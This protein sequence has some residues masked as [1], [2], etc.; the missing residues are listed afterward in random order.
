VVATPIGNLADLSPRAREVL[1]EV[2][3]VLAEDTRRVRKLFAIRTGVW[4]LHEHN[5]AREVPRLLAELAAGSDLALV[6]DAGTPLLA[7]PGYRL[8]KACREHGVPVL[9]VPGPSAAT[10][11]VAVSG[12]PPVPFTFGGFLPARAGPSRLEAYG[13]PAH[14]LVLLLSPHRLA[15]ELGACASHLGQAREAAL[16]AELTKVHER[17]VRGTLAEL[18][19]WAAGTQPRGEYTLVVAPPPAAA[20]PSPSPDA[21]RAAVDEA[22]ARGLDRATALREAARAL[23]VTRR[24]LY[25]LLTRRDSR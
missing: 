8:V 2:R 4:S 15:A 20:A 14:T 5:E 11:A 1:G 9:T 7:D 25:S 16:L 18:S 10:A 6:S 24:E 23:G 13:L 3:V 12:L 17:C 21:A 22:A 19:V